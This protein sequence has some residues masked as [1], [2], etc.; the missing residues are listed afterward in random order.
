MAR[1]E[2]WYW[3]RERTYGEV[4][5]AAYRD[6]WWTIGDG[7]DYPDERRV[8]VLAGRCNPPDPAIGATWKQRYDKILRERRKIEGQDPTLGWDYI[9]G[10]YWVRVPGRPQLVLAQFMEDSW[11]EAAGDSLGSK[12]SPAQEEA[13]HK[14]EIIDGPLLSPQ[15][16]LPSQR[17]RH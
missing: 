5:I 7:E 13:Y 9:D 2:G 14:V 16:P 4:L 15:V 6:G 10:Y 3:V 11:G 8:T 17:I 12:F 1:G